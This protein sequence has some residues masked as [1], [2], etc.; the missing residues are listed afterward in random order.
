MPAI[1]PDRG[2]LTWIA[3]AGLVLA[4]GCDPVRPG[5]S[6]IIGGPGPR[7]GV[8]QTAPVV[9]GD[10][11]D[12]TG[13]PVPEAQVRFYRGRGRDG[14]TAGGT[15]STFTARTDATGRFRI[16]SIPSGTWTGEA[17][18]ARERLAIRRSLVVPDGGTTEFGA[19]VVKPPGFLKGRVVLPDGALALG[20]EVFV[21]GT[22]AV[23]RTDASGS[24][25][26]SRLGEGTYDVVAMAPRRVPAVREG[27]VV[28]A[29]ETTEGGEWLLT[30]DRPVVTAVSPSVGAPGMR[31][32]V[33][34]RSFGATRSTTLQV[35]FGDALATVWNRLSDERLEVVVPSG[36][37]GRLVVVS[38]GVES[39]PW[40]LVVA[41]RLT[42]SPGHG[43]SSPGEVASWS[44]EPADVP[45][46]WR[47]EGPGEASASAPGTYTSPLPGLFRVSARAGG[48]ESQAFW[49]VSPYRIT[50]P[51]RVDGN[52]YPHLA[53]RL[54]DMRTWWQ[55]RYP[56]HE[57][58]LVVDG[59]PVW[60]SPGGGFALDGLPSGAPAASASLVAGGAWTADGPDGVAFYWYRDHSLWY[61]SRIA[62]T[63]FGQAMEAEHLYRLAGDGRSSRP[64][65][66][67]RG[68]EAGLPD[69]YDL[70]RDPSGRLVALFGSGY[71]YR[72]ELD[73]R[74]SW[75]AGNGAPPSQKPSQG[76]QST[77]VG[78]SLVRAVAVGPDGD[79]AVGSQGQVVLCSAH[80]RRRYGLDLQAGDVVPLFGP[81]VVT[82]KPR[83]D[84]GPR[85][86]TSVYHVEGLAIAPDGTL[87]VTDATR[88]VRA[89]YPDGICRTV[90][91]LP[92]GLDLLR[93]PRSGLPAGQVTLW[94]DGPM[95]LVGETPVVL[96][97]LSKQ[98]VALTPGS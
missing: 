46:T 85:Q 21:P 15:G 28:R 32:V 96:D 74:W 17:V 82:V 11:F 54:V 72:L 40:P 49:S 52:D 65:A 7:D 33:Q 66:G 80:A 87:F 47:I 77:G 27:L 67:S 93:A 90:A 42:L 48:L 3:L 26:F 18:D 19:W 37:T 25:T 79:L 92:T 73:G 51:G 50:L 89:L 88:T 95:W 59:T 62:Q 83:P 71:V 20:L 91:G 55:W 24:F 44:V 56:A 70:T 29:G 63:R 57:L 86:Q 53:G 13:R 4:L 94:P 2:P 60:Q 58:T 61:L 45:V 31:L 14:S 68:L 35:K 78:G 23:A 34:G 30:L 41:N 84:A 98:F 69:L 39:E 10:V 75:L 43:G 6:G 38:D 81:G 8:S 36:G 64:E 97:G 22:D 76:W 9:I 5:T 1:R 16:A 12:E